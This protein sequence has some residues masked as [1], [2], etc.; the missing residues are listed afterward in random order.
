VHYSVTQEHYKKYRALAEST[1]IRFNE[2]TY[3]TFG[4]ET[5]GELYAYQQRDQTLENLP[6]I[7]FAPWI[8]STRMFNKATKGLAEFELVCLAKHCLLTQTLGARP[9][10]IT[11]KE[12]R[13]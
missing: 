3:R 6:P 1:R 12:I 4:F 7:V 13:L 9:R 11:K 10:F 5:F 2:T 8:S